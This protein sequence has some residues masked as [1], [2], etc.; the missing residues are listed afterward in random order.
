ERMKALWSGWKS[1][2]NRTRNVPSTATLDGVSG[3]SPW[4]AAG[5]WAE[6]PGRRVAANAPAVAPAVPRRNCR[7]LE[8][9]VREDR[10]IIHSSP[11]C[12]NAYDRPLTG[13][14]ADRTT[15]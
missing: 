13:R 9:Q 6:A 14:G 4:V 2:A 10:R 8:D 11:L 5:V 12:R 3:T 7:R 15:A 1:S